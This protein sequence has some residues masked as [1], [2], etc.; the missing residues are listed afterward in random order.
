MNNSINKSIDY[1]KDIMSHWCNETISKKTC[2]I[3]QGNIIKCNYYSRFWNDVSGHVHIEDDDNIYQC[4]GTKCN[5]CNISICYMCCK[6]C[7]YCD[8]FLCP[9]CVKYIYNEFDDDSNKEDITIVS[10]TSFIAKCGKKCL[11][12][13]TF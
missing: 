6:Q 12:N 9:K 5:D 7:Q 1:V 10:K 13:T 3:C 4:T 8:R 2:H 11:Y